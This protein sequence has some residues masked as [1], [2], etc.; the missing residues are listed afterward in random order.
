MWGASHSWT[1]KKTTRALMLLLS[2]VDLGWLYFLTVVP[3][4]SSDC[5]WVMIMTAVKGDVVVGI[6]RV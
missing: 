5:P 4:V 6:K 3:G 1:P 2:N